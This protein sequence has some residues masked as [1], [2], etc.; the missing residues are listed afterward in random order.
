MI[1]QAPQKEQT[2]A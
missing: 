1:E 2:I